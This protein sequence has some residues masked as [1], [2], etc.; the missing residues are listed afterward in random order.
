VNFLFAI[1]LPYRPIVAPKYFSFSLH[2]RKP[3]IL[4]G[5]DGR[6]V[7]KVKQYYDWDAIGIEGAYIIKRQN[8]YYLFYFSWT[9]WYEIGY[10]T[11]PSI[12]GPWT[13]AGNNP[14]YGFI[15]K[16]G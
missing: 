1:L 14:F 3:L 7:P 16:N 11:A 4:P 10:A 6:L 15:L 9:R 5:Y 13:K 12:T 2:S 8:I